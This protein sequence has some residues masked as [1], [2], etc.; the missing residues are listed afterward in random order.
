M[1][2]YE[3]QIDQLKVQAAARDSI[4]Y[5][6]AFKDD[7]VGL[8]AELRD[9]GWTQTAISEALDIPWATL[10]RW[11]DDANKDETGQSEGF[12]P[13]EVVEDLEGAGVTLVSPAGWRIEGLTVAQAVEAARRLG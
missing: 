2:Q 8:V 13:V 11:C 6:E 5:P 3:E 9:A 1:S 10:G 4:R 12:R 7:A